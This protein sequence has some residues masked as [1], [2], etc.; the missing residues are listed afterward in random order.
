MAVVL[1][2]MLHSLWAWE[3]LLGSLCLSCIVFVWQFIPVVWTYTTWRR[4]LRLWTMRSRT[5]RI[6]AVLAVV[7][8]FILTLQYIHRPRTPS[9]IVITRHQDVINVTVKLCTDIKN[10]NRNLTT[11]NAGIFTSILQRIVDWTIITTICAHSSVTPWP[12]SSDIFISVKTTSSNHN[13][14]LPL[15]LTTW[16]QTVHAK[17]VRICR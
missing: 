1:M 14:R 2:A 3:N 16:M 8:L 12:D 15:L 9:L 10:V 17:Q 4:G 6:I 13:S 7:S 11:Y 5:L